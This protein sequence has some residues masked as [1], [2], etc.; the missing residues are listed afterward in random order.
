[1]QEEDKIGYACVPNPSWIYPIYMFVL[2]NDQLF[3]KVLFIFP[4]NSQKR[5]TFSK[6]HT[7]NNRKI[8]PETLNMFTFSKIHTVNKGEE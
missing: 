1:M 8:E 2:T 5:L 4:K 7:I 3:M 6:I